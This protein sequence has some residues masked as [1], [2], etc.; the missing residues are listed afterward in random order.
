MLR[1]RCFEL[2]LRFKNVAAR[3]E[4]VYSWNN[5]YIFIIIII[6]TYEKSH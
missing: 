2:L 6:G 3:R 4:Q 1:R 5:V